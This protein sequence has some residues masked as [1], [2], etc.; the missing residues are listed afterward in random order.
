M[1]HSKKFFTLFLLVYGMF[2]LT[3]TWNIV[4]SLPILAVVCG[5]LAVAIAAHKQHGYAPSVFLVIHMIIEW[6]YHARHGG[7][8]SSTEIVFHAVH[9]LLDLIFLWVE[10]KHYG[11]WAI[12]FLVG[13]LSLL[14]GIVWYFYVPAPPPMRSF[15]PFVQALVPHT[16]TH[17]WVHSFVLGGM[18]GC[19]LSHLY[20][21]PKWKH[22]HGDIH[23]R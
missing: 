21:I 2:L 22:V 9:A 11:K 12:H 6:Y 3:H 17:G 18:L 7:H 20:M 8:Y 1:A 19:V 13:V 14:V 4:S 15:T 5:G 10:S 16:H 23:S